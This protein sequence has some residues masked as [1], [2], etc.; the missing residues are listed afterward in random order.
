VDLFATPNPLTSRTEKN[1]P[2]ATSVLTPKL[3]T[4]SKLAIVE[5]IGLEFLPWLSAVA[6]AR[7]IRVL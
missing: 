1:F 5:D 2:I 3:C 4:H 7:S 6:A